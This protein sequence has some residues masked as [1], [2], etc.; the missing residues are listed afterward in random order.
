ML[1]AM[2]APVWCQS[3][4][5]S[6]PHYEFSGSYSYVRAD[7][8]SDQSFDLHGGSASGAYRFGKWTSIAGDFGGYDFTPLSNG[9]NGRLYTFLAGPRF[10]FRQQAKLTPFSQILL[11]VARHT[12]DTPTNRA[13]EN[14]FAFLLGG[15][16]DVNLK[17]HLAIRA[18]EADYLLTRFGGATGNSASQHN[19]RLSTGIVFRF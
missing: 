12:A 11:G 17:H 18:V 2:C 13:G 10:S 3:T 4:P 8:S 9:V 7:S 1:L 16:L 14:S 5:Q 15:G 6:A 19:L